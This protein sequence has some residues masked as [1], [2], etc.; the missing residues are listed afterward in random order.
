MTRQDNNTHTHAHTQKK[1]E[2]RT[3]FLLKK[4]PFK[5]MNKCGKIL[6]F[7]YTPEWPSKLNKIKEMNQ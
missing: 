5:C 4:L 6:M 7:T 2:V 3:F 1:T